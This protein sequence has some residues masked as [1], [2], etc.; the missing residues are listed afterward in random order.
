MRLRQ[1][2]QSWSTQ[3]LEIV[4][5]GITLVAALAM[6]YLLRRRIS[7]PYGK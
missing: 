6:T 3:R 4:G 2:R 7:P 5:A 1:F